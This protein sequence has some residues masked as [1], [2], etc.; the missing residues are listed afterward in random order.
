MRICSAMECCKWQAQGARG[1]VAAGGEG[2][3]VLSLRTAVAP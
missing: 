3:W 2:R 1:G